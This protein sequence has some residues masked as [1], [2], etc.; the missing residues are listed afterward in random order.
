MNDQPPSFWKQLFCKHEWEKIGR[1]NFYE[2][3][4]LQ[5]K[6]LAYSRYDRWQCQKCSKITKQRIS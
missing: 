1:L 3:V 2:D 6:K 5:E 4:I